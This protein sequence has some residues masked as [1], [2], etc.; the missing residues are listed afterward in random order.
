MVGDISGVGAGIAIVVVVES[1]PAVSRMARGGAGACAS[2][3]LLPTSG[4]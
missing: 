4:C 3:E 1:L 2:G